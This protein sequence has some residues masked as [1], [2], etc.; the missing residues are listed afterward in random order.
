MHEQR[1]TPTLHNTQYR[2]G[3]ICS[4]PAFGAFLFIYYARNT[5]AASVAYYR[6]LHRKSIRK[7]AKASFIVTHMHVSR[8]SCWPPPANRPAN[9]ARG[10]KG[11]LTLQDRRRMGGGGG[12]TVRTWCA[13]PRPWGEKENAKK[14]E[15]ARGKEKASARVVFSFPANQ[16]PVDDNYVRE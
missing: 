8:R 7:N 3:L 16:H 15:Q 5:G 9:N 1:H 11:H 2:F 13:C 4:A 10:R 6:R 14:K 12:G